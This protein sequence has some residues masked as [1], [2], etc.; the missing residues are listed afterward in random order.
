MIFFFRKRW[1]IGGCIVEG[2]QKRHCLNNNRREGGDEKVNQSIRVRDDRN[3]GRPP[4]PSNTSVYN[5]AEPMDRSPGQI[6]IAV[7][8]A[9]AYCT[10]SM[11]L[12]H[13]LPPRNE[14]T[15]RDSGKLAYNIVCPPI[16]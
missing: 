7:L 15:A 12:I 6:D 8:P 10:I 9:T 2:M 3:E 5:S 1:R 14:Q 11:K 13:N 4:P 16:H